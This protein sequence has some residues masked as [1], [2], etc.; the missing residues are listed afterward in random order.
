MGSA[1]ANPKEK[2]TCFVI[3]GFGEKT[4][5]ETGRVLNLDKS[6]KNIIKPAVEAA[7]LTCVRADEIRHSG[8]IDV[9][10][11]SAAPDRGCRGRRPVHV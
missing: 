7:G 11:V 4:D 5:Y 3:M 10:D 1:E 2:K 6:Y 8:I 9:P